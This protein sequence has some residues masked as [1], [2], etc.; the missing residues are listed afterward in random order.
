MSAK[1]IQAF[2]Y[3]IAMQD[4]PLSKAQVMALCGLLN[5]TYPPEAV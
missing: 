3:L 1:D 5:I 4:K 2:L